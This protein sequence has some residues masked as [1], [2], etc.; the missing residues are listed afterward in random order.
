MKSRPSATVETDLTMW[1][2]SAALKSGGVTAEPYR[3]VDTATCAWRDARLKLAKVGLRPT[4]QRVLLG[5]LLF[6]RGKRHVTAEMLFEEAMNAG[7]PVSLATVYNVLNRF[8][9]AGLLQQIGV[10]GSKTYFDTNTAD[11]HHLFVEE[12]RS[13]M[14]IPSVNVDLHELPPALSGYEVARIELVVRLKRK[15]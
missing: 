13:L 4:R 11:H 3:E 7:M 5:W 8:T 6:S 9:A 2:A 12:Q 10:D 1:S 14:D 15:N